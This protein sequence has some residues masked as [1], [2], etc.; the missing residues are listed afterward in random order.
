[1]VTGAVIVAIDHETRRVRGASRIRRHERSP[2]CRGNGLERLLP[3][4]TRRYGHAGVFAV[5]DDRIAPIL[6]NDG[7]ESSG[8][9]SHGSSPPARPQATAASGD[10]RPRT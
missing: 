1:M 4:R 9:I 10:A 5:L 2:E 8:E 7:T 3:F 6:A